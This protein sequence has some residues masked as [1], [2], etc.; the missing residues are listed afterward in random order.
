MAF[1]P[2]FAFA[3]LLL[4]NIVTTAYSWPRLDVDLLAV[5]GGSRHGKVPSLQ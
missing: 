2:A 1:V 4:P 3:A 5:G